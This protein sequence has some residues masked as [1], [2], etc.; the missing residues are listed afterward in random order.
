MLTAEFY[1]SMPTGIPHTGT[2]MPVT[3]V[4]ISL[5]SSPVRWLKK[6]AGVGSCLDQA[7]TGEQTGAGLLQWRTVEGSGVG[8]GGRRL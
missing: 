8:S 5:V 4:T 6:A 3:T 1:G 2:L 7:Q